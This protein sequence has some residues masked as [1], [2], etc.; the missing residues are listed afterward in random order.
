MTFCWLH[1]ILTHQLFSLHNFIPH[2]N[3]FIDGK[4]NSFKLTSFSK[5]KLELFKLSLHNPWR[6]NCY[7]S[8][9]IGSN[10]KNSP[11][12]KQKPKPN[13]GSKTATVTQRP[14]RR[15]WG[16]AD[17]MV[18]GGRTTDPPISASHDP[19]TQWDRRI[20]FI[21]L[22][23][24]FPIELLGFFYFSKYWSTTGLLLELLWVVDV[25][26]LVWWVDGIY[27]DFCYCVGCVHFVDNVALHFCFSQWGSSFG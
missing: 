18:L 2:Y 1:I 19:L 17:H 10:Y 7:H 9:D 25:S 6:P 4:S 27:Y 12:V 23:F 26:L 20:Y 14:I 16:P 3:Y 24:C 21:F 13:F 22:I 11:T 8:N 5:F 15:D